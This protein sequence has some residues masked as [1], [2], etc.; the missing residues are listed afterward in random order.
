MSISHRI[1]TFFLLAGIAFLVAFFGYIL[2]NSLRCNL[3]VFGALAFY[4]GFWFHHHAGQPQTSNRLGLVR[5]VL[6]R[7]K[8]P[9]QEKNTRK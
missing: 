3:L 4:L 7:R 8:K 6:E 9:E 5:K 1:G 2:S